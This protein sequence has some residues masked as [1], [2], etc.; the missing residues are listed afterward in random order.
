[1]ILF[2]MAKIILM[3]WYLHL[4]RLGVFFHYETREVVFKFPKHK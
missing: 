2:S 3:G 4:I 1:M